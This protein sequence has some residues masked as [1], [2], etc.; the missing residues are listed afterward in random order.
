MVGNRRGL[1][2]CGLHLYRTVAIP[3]GVAPWPQN[4]HGLERGGFEFDQVVV[5]N[6][7]GPCRTPGSS[8]RFPHRAPPSLPVNRHSIDFPYSLAIPG[9]RACLRLRAGLVARGRRFT[10]RDLRNVG[11]VQL[12]LC[13][14]AEAGAARCPLADVAAEKASRRSRF[15]SMDRSELRRAERYLRAQGMYLDVERRLAMLDAPEFTSLEDIQKAWLVLNCLHNHID[16]PLDRMQA[17]ISHL[18]HGRGTG[19]IAS[20]LADIFIQGIGRATTELDSIPD[21]TL[22]L[23]FLTTAGSLLEYLSDAEQRT[24]VGERIRGYHCT[25]DCYQNGG[26][27]A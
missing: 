27:R 22:R 18:E 17:A 5:G 16:A 8:G 19:A 15:L 9:L 7:W 3:L 6:R 2:V 10:P 1:A 12:L 13:A 24:C 26:L 23:F 20:R 11:F 4:A 25:S 21:P 14:I